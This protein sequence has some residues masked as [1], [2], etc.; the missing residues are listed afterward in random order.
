MPAATELDAGAAVSA[1]R[2]G[3]CSSRPR[4]PELRVVHRAS[5]ICT[6][7][8][9]LTMSLQRQGYDSGRATTTACGNGHWR[10]TSGCPA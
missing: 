6:G 4:S 1:P 9:L 7:I 10:V 8:S 2:S 3:S 5:N